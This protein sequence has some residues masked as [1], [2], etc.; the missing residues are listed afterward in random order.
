MFINCNSKED[1]YGN[2][3]T[4]TGEAE[5][6]RELFKEYLT[7]IRPKADYGIVS[8]YTGQNTKLIDTL[9]PI[10][11]HENVRSIDSWQGREC[12]IIIFSCVRSNPRKELGFLARPRR[13]NVALTRAKHGMIIVG[14]ADTL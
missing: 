5:L 7:T 3:K 10:G 6:I 12:D 11:M 1:E 9:R 2:S 14:N 13:I 4:N 8:P